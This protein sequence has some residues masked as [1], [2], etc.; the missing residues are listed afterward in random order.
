MVT[1]FLEFVVNWRMG[2]L[3]LLVFGFAPGALLRLIVLAFHRDDP[4][5]SEMLAELHA[6]PRL[7]RPLWVVEQL[8]VALSEG[9]WERIAWAATGR[10]IERWHLNS[11]VKLNRK[12]PKTFWIPSEDE[13]QAIAP[14]V[15]VKLM[16]TIDNVWGR[17]IWGERMW[18]QVVTIKKRHIIG[19]LVNAPFAIPRL[20]HGDRI[21]FKRDHIIDI[22]W[23]AELCECSDQCVAEPRQLREPLLLCT[24]C[25]G[26]GNPGHS[27]GTPPG[28]PE[29]EGP[30]G[31]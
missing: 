11:G 13:K 4:R 12:N 5:R 16:F 18:V 23:D 1:E 6:V 30:E 22:D 29:V 10:I 3:V 14:G 19:R 31:T 17:Q 24:G 9:V 26:H 15:V 8:E 21:K 20:D 28:K 25:N 7:E 27:A 2:L